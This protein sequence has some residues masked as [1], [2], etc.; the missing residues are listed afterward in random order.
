[1]SQFKSDERVVTKDGKVHR[2][3]WYTKCKTQLFVKACGC[4]SGDAY[5]IKI[6]NI[7]SRG[8][9]HGNR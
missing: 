2:V 4:K 3:L 7:V 5:K 8:E 9:A 6:E 1:M